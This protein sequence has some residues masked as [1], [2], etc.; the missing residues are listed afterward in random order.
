L[1]AFWAIGW[2]VQASQLLHVPVNRPTAL[3][4]VISCSAEI[5]HSLVGDNVLLGIIPDNLG[6]KQLS[7][8][9]SQDNAVIQQDK[10][11]LALVGPQQTQWVLHK[12]SRWPAEQPALSPCVGLQ[13]LFCVRSAL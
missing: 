8:G 5:I 11:P 2:S 1:S 4:E 12:L 6:I 7:W 10:T 9:F 13:L 3:L